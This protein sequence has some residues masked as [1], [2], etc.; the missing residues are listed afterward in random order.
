M[1]VHRAARNS[2]STQTCYLCRSSGPLLDMKCLIIYYLI[3]VFWAAAGEGESF[4]TV[5]L[6]AC[7]NSVQWLAKFSLLSTVTHAASCHVMVLK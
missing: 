6:R 3:A 4:G 5:W 2:V 1:G 7:I